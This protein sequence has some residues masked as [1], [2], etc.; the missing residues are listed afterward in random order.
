MYALAARLRPAIRSLVRSPGATLVSMAV[1]ALGIGAATALFSLYNSL[2]LRPLP[3]PG[4]AQVMALRLEGGPDQFQRGLCLEEVKDLGPLVPPVA[5]LVLEKAEV[6]RVE[7]GELKASFQAFITSSDYFPA[8]GVRPGHGSGYRAG[9]PGVIISQAL[10]HAAFGAPASLAGCRLRV[11]GAWLEVL[12]VAPEGFQGLQPTAAPDLWIPGEAIRLWNPA[13]Y[14]AVAQRGGSDLAAYVRLSP[15]AS[16]L[17]GEAALQPRVQA[18]R[19][20]HRP[21]P[22]RVRLEPLAGLRQDAWKLFFPH[23]S[24]LWVALGLLLLLACLNV[25]Q[26]QAAQALLRRREVATRLALGGRPGVLLAGTALELCLLVAMGTILALPV[27]FL[28]ARGLGRL[29][30]PS[31]AVLHVDVHLDLRVLGFALGLLVLMA[32]ALLAATGWRLM[33]QQPMTG[34]RNGTGDTV[35]FGPAHR[36]LLGIQLALALALL[37][38]AA[39]VL[40]G[41]RRTLNRPLGLDPHHVFVLTLEVPQGTPP[42]E[43]AAKLAALRRQV[44]AIPGVEAAAVSA[45]SP[46]DPLSLKFIIVTKEGQEVGFKANLVSKDYFRTLRIPLLEG[47][48]FG[49]PRPQAK[50]REVILSRS[51]ARLLFPREALVVGRTVAGLEVVGVVEDHVQTDLTI[52]PRGFIRLDQV[53]MNW[54]CLVVRSNLPAATLLPR[55]DR[56]V[57]AV[58]PRWPLMRAEPLEAKLLRQQQPQ[59]LASALLSGLGALA[60]LLAFAG[61]F[62]LQSHL[63]C[64]RTREAG[65][66]IALGATPWSV[67]LTFTRPLLV[68]AL[69]GLAGGVALV[70]AGR[71]VLASLLG[72]LGAVA[73]PSLLTSAAALLVTALAAAWL[74]AMRAGR[75]QPAEA[76]RTE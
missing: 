43:R 9:D 54:Q 47:H 58:D 76:L 25:A 49:E 4:G 24:V 37:W 27:A 36:A 42:E 1:L 72:D 50:A 15:G 18:W 3:I 7:A 51:Q 34:L 63:T 30:P 35:R 71:G 11:N 64:Q 8:L 59:R 53:G 2:V 55:L 68:P 69:A 40:G 32:L 17:Q 60:A 70:L 12:G 31:M 29:A 16:A 19:F 52:Q 6:V 67:A 22:P 20:E 56:E 10:W 5:T 41:L 26:M 14:D 65:L 74:P 13:E 21:G 57:A 45:T 33:R 73:W 48:E 39:S 62:G 75:L 44:A 66:R 28:L 38:S 61:I 46:L 23:S